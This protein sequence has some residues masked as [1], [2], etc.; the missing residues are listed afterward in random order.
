MKSFPALSFAVLRITKSP[1]ATI[2]FYAMESHSKSDTG[3]IEWNPVKQLL[4]YPG[5]EF[6]LI[7]LNQPIRDRSLF[8]DLW[9]SGTYDHPFIYSLIS[10]I[11]MI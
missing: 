3:S 4:G 8:D 5:Y 6:I 11:S 1:V 7:T 9:D 10:M 2:Q